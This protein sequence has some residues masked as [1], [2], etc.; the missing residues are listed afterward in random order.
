MKKS[1]Y[2]LLL[3]LFAL[4]GSTAAQQPAAGLKIMSL[5]V[6]VWTRDTDPEDP[7][8]YKTRMEAMERM[9]L[10]QAPDIICLQE[11]MI[12]IGRY[13]PDGYRKVGISLRKTSGYR[14]NLNWDSV[15]CEGIR[16]FNVHSNWDR[17]V[18]E[19]DISDINAALNGPAV[20]CGDWNNSLSVIRSIG[21]DMQEAG[22]FVEKPEGDTFTN[23]KDPEGSHGVIDFFFL[24][25]IRPAKYEMITDGYGAERISDHYPIMLTL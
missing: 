16:I 5:N 18:I 21:L 22:E 14:Y 20:A 17:K 9:L 6:R 15:I 12:P 24:K 7:H 19:R 23:F 1:L 11:M 3:S 4:T 10:D 8:S 13:V 25:D 2:L